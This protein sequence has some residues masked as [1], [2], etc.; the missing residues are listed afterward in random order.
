MTDKEFETLQN[1][2]IITSEFDRLF[3][4]QVV[5]QVLKGQVNQVF[6]YT[7]MMIVLK[8]SE[9]FLIHTSLNGKTTNT[10]REIISS[11]TMTVYHYK[12]KDGEADPFKDRFKNCDDENKSKKIDKLKSD[13]DILS[14]LAKLQLD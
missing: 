9:V 2:L 10:Q 8:P 4:W 12:L 14:S 3:P 5:Q 1:S 11:I 7:K 13:E 6:H